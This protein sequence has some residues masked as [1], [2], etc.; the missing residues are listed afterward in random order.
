MPGTV[1]N[2]HVLD[3]A[4]ADRSGPASSGG[5]WVWYIAPT[6]VALLVLLPLGV[7]LL[8]WTDLQP[9]VWR[10][11]LE[12]QLARL[13]WNTLFLLVGVGFCVTILGVG[14]AW[15]TAVCEFPGR[16][17]LDWGLMLPLALPAY[18]LAF[19]VLGQ[20]DYMGPVQVMLRRCLGDHF[21]MDVRHPAT[22]VLVLSGVLYPYVYMLSRSA[23]QVQGR[24]AM[25]AARSLGLNPRQAFLRVSLPM[26]RPAIVAGLSLSLMETLADF[27]AVAVFNY[28]TFTTAIYKT[29]FGLYNI[30]A[31]AQLASLL[32]FFVAL[33]LLGE[34]IGR[35]RR[36]F[37][38]AG[39]RLRYQRFELTGW[40]RWA[41]ASAGFLV[42]GAS[43]L[44]PVGQLLWWAI[45]LVDVE[46]TVRYWDLLAHTLLLALAAVCLI[47]PLALLVA[48]SLKQQD[49]AWLKVS[50][51]ISGL[52]Y[53]LPGSVLAAGVAL[54]FGAIDGAFQALFALEHKLILGGG[55]G[56]LL[57]AYL[58]RFFA[59]AYGP[60]E[61]GLQQIRPS[62]PEAASLLGAGRWRIFR[63]VYMPM[64]IP[65][66]V[67]AAL[68]VLVDVMKEMP[69]TLLMRPFGWDT[70]AVKVYELT[71]EG[72]WQRA[73]L[74]ALS[75]VLIGLLPVALILRRQERALLG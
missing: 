67:T 38:E 69:V 48:V 51:F 25:D 14:L 55:L 37:S 74:P 58:V 6:L 32:L 34:R 39:G 33:A 28:D 59:V 9:E 19:V 22:V 24:D 45:E 68:L 73:A 42:F 50:G 13:L 72:E 46:L 61:T 60:V 20:W 10:H 18:V 70:L 71:S 35:G 66:I 75:I 17:F 31:A 44:L 52:G 56:A 29:W 2:L 30:Q 7:I 27:G 23:F 54:S 63:R 26:A 57:L 4:S 62:I 53:A 40:R 1:D 5:R 49:S 16:R 64:I 8:S 65:G 12:T 43:F 41:A 47:V 15:L 21:G 11:L 3:G 36:Q